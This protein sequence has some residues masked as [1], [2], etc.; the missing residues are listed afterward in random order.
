ML[1]TTRERQRLSLTDKISF[2]TCLGIVEK[3]VKSHQFVILASY[4]IPN[5]SHRIDHLQA[6][7]P[8]SVSEGRDI[9]WKIF[10]DPHHRKKAN[11]NSSRRRARLKAVTLGPRRRT[12]SFPTTRRKH[13]S[14]YVR[15]NQMIAS[16]PSISAAYPDVVD[17]REDVRT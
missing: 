6:Q 9:V 17:R 16:N 10:P 15:N 5:S 13:C 8:T 2:G 11:M 3:R 7:L 14:T 4:S 1:S 12:V